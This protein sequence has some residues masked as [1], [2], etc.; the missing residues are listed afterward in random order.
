M[1]DANTSTSST[2]PIREAKASNTTELQSASKYLSE[3]W[4]EIG[5]WR[6]EIGDWRLEIGD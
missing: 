1:D 3:W 2:I 6:L 5:D 4:V